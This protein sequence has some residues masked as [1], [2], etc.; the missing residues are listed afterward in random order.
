MQLARKTSLM[1]LLFKRLLRPRC[2][3]LAVALVV[4][5]M[6][7]WAIAEEGS[8]QANSERPTLVINNVVT[9]NAS[10]LT[11]GDVG[12][13]K[14]ASVTDNDLANRLRAVKLGPAPTPGSSLVLLGDNILQSINSSG[15]DSET[16]GY[17][18]P[19]KVR[20][21]RSGRQLL[22][23]E[24]L[25]IVRAKLHINGK[26][27][28]RVRE[29]KFPESY[30]IPNGPTRIAVE[31]LGQPSGGIVPL[32]IEVYVAEQSAARF[33]ASAVVDYWT[34]IPVLARDIERGMLIEHDDLQIV[35][36]NRNKFADNIV[37][38]SES[39]IGRRAKAHLR[40]G[41]P[42]RS[43]LIDIPAVV[44]KGARISV[45]YNAAGINASVTAIAMEDGLK[46]ETI[47][48]RNDSSNKVIKAIVKSPQ[49][50]EV[51]NP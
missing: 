49:H 4:I 43:N 40:A 13:I 5:Y 25:D 17:F 21:E 14:S 30:I 10:E 36:L 26:S 16:I 31:A 2:C 12:Q 11:L 47:R 3:C 1:H 45:I 35:R 6:P 9:I 32:R 33:L 42:L 38:N 51:A 22:P 39:I 20:V 7:F 50:A 28:L 24:V 37:D 29:V 18:I 41:E 48:F 8:S 23:A 44:S 46:G 15:I 19:A 34:D 27:D